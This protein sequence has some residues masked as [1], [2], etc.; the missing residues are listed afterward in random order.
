[1]W[2]LNLKKGSQGEG[3]GR[4]I[5]QLSSSQVETLEG[6]AAVLTKRQ[7]ADFFGISEN[8]LRAI[9]ERQPEVSEAY[10]KGKAQ[11]IVG[12]AQNLIQ[13][14]EDGNVTAAIFYLKTQAGWSET[15]SEQRDIPQMNIIL[16]H[17]TD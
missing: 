8:T 17:D 11:A 12:V 4:P 10:K 5:A 1:M 15:L 2:A 16:T 7:I 9:E 13:Q 14:A 6:L 3:G